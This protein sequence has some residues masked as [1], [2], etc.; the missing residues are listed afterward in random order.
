ML[1]S[2]S[3]PFLTCKILLF[4]IWRLHIVSIRTHLYTLHIYTIYEQINEN[5]TGE[6][7]KI[8]KGSRKT[9]N[10]VM[11]GH[12]I[13]SVVQAFYHISLHIRWTY[14]YDSYLV[15]HQ[16]PKRF[17]F[18]RIY[19]QSNIL[20]VKKFRKWKLQLHRQILVF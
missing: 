16:N 11:L 3:H 4:R 19:L 1:H 18:Q 8:I 13:E 14:V 12:S 2:G 17:E 6:R 9:E 20:A 5:P 15:I 10:S 7:V